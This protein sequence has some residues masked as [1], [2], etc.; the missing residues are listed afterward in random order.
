M[1]A[2][3]PT[4]AIIY[5]R[6]SDAKQKTRGDGLGSQETRCRE[7]AAYR[8]LDVVEVFKDD[9]T[10]ATERRPA[11][12][13]ALAY[14]KKHKRDPHVIIIDD[15]SRLA[16]DVVAFRSLRESITK[17]GGILESPSIV[18]RE[19]S[20]SLFV[21]N[22]L[23]SAAQHQRQKN[24]EQTKN[25]MRARTMN[26]YWVFQA[27]VGYRYEKVAGHGKMLVRHE[28]TASVI[29][30]ALEGYASGR[31]QTKAE[32][33]RWLDQQP[34]FPKA[35]TA[36][37]HNQRVDDILN[38][39][40]YAG[41]ID[42]PEW[43]VRMVSAKHDALIDYPTYKAIQDRLTAKAKVPARKDLN[44]DFPLRGFVLCDC[45]TPLTA[46]WSK[47]RVAR[48]PYYLCPKRGCAH[49]GKSIR[50]DALEGEFGQ[51][52]TS[53]RPAES[54]MRFADARFRDLWNEQLTRSKGGATALQAELKKIDRDIEQLMDRI[55]EAESPALITAYERRIGALEG[56]RT[57]M[58]E[59]VA[60]CG[61]PLADY[62]TTFRTA[63]QFLANPCNLWESPQLE[64]KRAV[65]KLAFTE[66]LSYVRGS[67]F[68]TALTSSPFRVLSALSGSEEEMARPI[69]FEPMAFA[70]GGQRSIH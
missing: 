21:E 9:F 54:L 59:A 24:A 35:Y 27:P 36:A 44:E 53:M 68:R 67:G 42:L 2:D 16:R 10:G 14:L 60:N 40:V 61:R 17:A 23:A 6:V 65:L 69:G 38:R 15:L 47:G 41:Y 13:A 4:K 64:D 1:T 52:L 12:Q 29:Q 51:L 46:C 7:Y 30:E 5:A 33:G 32:V 43:Q 18:F 49:Y 11:M 55:V 8:K 39:V 45:G 19:D 25:R 57:E 66:R 37:L 26:G 56:K 58:K 62:D 31:F 48:H 63:L 34:A 22:V 70:S 28:P 20:D 50:R 3:K